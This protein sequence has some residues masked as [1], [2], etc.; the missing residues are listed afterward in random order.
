MT[1][2]TA[3]SGLFSTTAP[4]STHRF[5]S[6]SEQKQLALAANLDSPVLLLEDADALARKG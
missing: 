6:K 3:P 2:R 1:D 5:F 4:W